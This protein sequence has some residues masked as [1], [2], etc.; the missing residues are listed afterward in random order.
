MSKK[1]VAWDLLA[2]PKTASSKPKG[3]YSSYKEMVAAKTGQ[4]EAVQKSQQSFQDMEPALKQK[5]FEY[6]VSKKPITV[7]APIRYH[8]DK[9]VKSD[10]GSAGYEF[11]ISQLE[12]GTTLEFVKADKTMGTWIFKAMGPEGFEEVEI[13]ST[14]V[15]TIPGAYNSQNV[16]QNSGFYGLLMNTSITK[17]VMEAKTNE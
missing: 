8:A 6:L 4:S 3:Q 12:P 11:G 15:I 2:T 9:I 10:N 1:I 14:P 5:L 17:E 13:Y 7:L 16:I